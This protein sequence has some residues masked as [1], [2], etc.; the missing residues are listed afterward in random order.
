MR[1]VLKQFSGWVVE[2]VI[3]KAHLS[4]GVAF[5]AIAATPQNPVWEQARSYQ[6]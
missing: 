6:T 2:G 3:S 5:S 4:A 1:Q